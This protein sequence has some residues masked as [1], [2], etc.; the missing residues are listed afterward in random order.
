MTVLKF[1][2]VI[3]MFIATVWCIDCILNKGK[4]VTVGKVEVKQHLT[5]VACV[6]IALCC[7]AYN[8]ACV[9]LLAMV[10]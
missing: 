1:L 3:L 10:L 4:E 5:A 9:Y 6:T 7:I 2:I 8:A